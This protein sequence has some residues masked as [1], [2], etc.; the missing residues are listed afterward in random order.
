MMQ[1][2]VKWVTRS[3]GALVWMLVVAALSAGG[4]AKRPAV[5]SAEPVDDKPYRLESEGQVPPFGPDAV[6]R[7]VD[8]VDTFEDLEVVEEGI[9]VEDVEPVREVTSEPVDST[10]MVVPGYRVQVF[11]SGIRDNAVAMQGRM[12]RLLEVPV[13]LELLDGIY[14]VR[15]GD[16]PNRAQA[17]ALLQRCREAGVVDAWIVTSDV[18]ILRGKE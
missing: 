1:R 7:E 16:C 11:A 8:R 14:K 4:C 10:T 3:R 17:E 2:N 9:E 18:V 6:R 12:E 13:Y 15:V 5:R